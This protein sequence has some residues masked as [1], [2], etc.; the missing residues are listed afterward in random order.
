MGTKYATDAT[1]E[2]EKKVQPYANVIGMISG[3]L[4]AV[5]CTVVCVFLSSWSDKYGRRPILLISLAGK[6]IF[7]FNETR[8]SIKITRSL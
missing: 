5:I 6:Y 3:L 1:E 8:E 4:D 2:L 7:L